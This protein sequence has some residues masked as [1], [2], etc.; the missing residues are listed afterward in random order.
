MS[1]YLYLDNEAGA[2]GLDEGSLQ[3]SLQESAAKY[4]AWDL[5]MRWNLFSRVEYIVESS[6]Y[7]RWPLD[8]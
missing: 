7:V 3:S 8:T 1:S 6:W 2:M 4:S 5:R